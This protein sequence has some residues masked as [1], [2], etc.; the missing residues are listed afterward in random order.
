MFRIVRQGGVLLIL[1]LVIFTA[2]QAA[3]AFRGTEIERVLSR[4]SEEQAKIQTLQAS[5]RQEKTVGLL[6]GPEVST[7]TFVFSRPNRA[8]WTYD[9]PKRVDMLVADGWM[10]TYYPDLRRAE[11]I[12]IKKYEDRIFRYLGAGTG[13]ISDLDAFFEFQ[14]IDTSTSPTY[15]L[16]LT[17]RSKR[18]AKRVKQ[19]KV[20]ID[21][22][23]YLTTAF[24]YQEGDGDLTRYEFSA[25]KV[26]RPLPDSKF[27]LSLPSSVSVETMAGSR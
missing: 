12:E 9:Q 7:G 13:A 21:R 8:L 1:S 6:A 24:E 11:R 20:W 27:E 2:A 22:E 14:L 10:T 16:E 18:V 3:T 15:R 5:F 23:S 25:V 19:I 4:L 17:P 26:N